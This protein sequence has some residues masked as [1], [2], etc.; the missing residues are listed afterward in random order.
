MNMFSE[1]FIVELVLV[2]RAYRCRRWTLTGNTSFIFYF[3]MFD[4]LSKSN[5]LIFICDRY[6]LCRWMCSN[7]LYEEGFD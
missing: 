3:I 4:N 5:K 1:L 6:S 7:S 2:V